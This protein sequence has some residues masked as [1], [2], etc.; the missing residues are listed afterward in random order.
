MPGILCEH[1]TAVCCKYI[2]L[3]IDTPTEQSDFDPIRW[4]LLHEGISV[5]VEDADWYL[6]VQTTCR[7]LQ[8][9]HRCGIYETRPQICRDYTT[10]NCDYHSGDYGWEQHFTAP[11][12]LDAYVEQW[13]LDRAARRSKRSGAGRKDKRKFPGGRGPRVQLTSR[14]PKARGLNISSTTDLRGVALP[15]LP[16]S[17]IT[18]GSSNGHARPSGPRT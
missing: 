14:K 15:V 7:H 6:L 11:E 1:C 17:A 2:A 3:P 4:Y 9:D 10:E 12:H 16:L 5:F 8:A 13:R 18:G